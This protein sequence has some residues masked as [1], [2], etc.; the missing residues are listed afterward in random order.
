MLVILIA[1]G[2]LGLI[3]LLLAISRAAALAD[4]V[5]RVEAAERAGEGAASLDASTAVV[6]MKVAAS[7]A[8]AAAAAVQAT[9][10]SGRRADTRPNCAS[11]IR[12]RAETWSTGR[13]HRSCSN[14][15]DDTRPWTSN[16]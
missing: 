11:G 15:S 8:S 9:R 16:P 7:A 12:R 14:R 13:I 1:V 10:A 2:W 6:M 4:H 5:V 3:V